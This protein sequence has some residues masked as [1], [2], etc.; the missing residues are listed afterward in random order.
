M[1]FRRRYIPGAPSMALW[2]HTPAYRN[3][4]AP[5]PLVYVVFANC[6]V[7]QSPLTC[8]LHNAIPRHCVLLS[9]PPP[10]SLPDLNRPAHT[11]RLPPSNSLHTFL[12]PEGSS[13][14]CAQEHPAE[15]PAGGGAHCGAGY[16]RRGQ[17]G[18]RAGNTGTIV[19]YVYRI[20]RYDCLY[21]RSAALRAAAE[22][23][24]QVCMC[25][26]SMEKRR[27]RALPSGAGAGG[28]DGGEADIRPGGRRV[29]AGDSG[30]VWGYVVM[31]P[32][33][34]AGRAS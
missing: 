23:I 16:P 21:K 18:G 9:G 31:S 8:P 3:S 1:C 24:G 11:F 4:Y 26:R 33:G 12:H 22:G 6:G 34:P 7:M 25:V 27:R 30:G 32:G 17:L 29:Q 2:C 14:R 5:G 28:G 15:H 20:L 19:R 13:S 10:R